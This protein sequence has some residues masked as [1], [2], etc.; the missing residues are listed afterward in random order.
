MVRFR[1]GSPKRSS[2]HCALKP[3]L[4]VVTVDLDGVVEGLEGLEVVG[5]LRV[6]H[7]NQV[8]DLRCLQGPGVSLLPGF[9]NK[10][11]GSSL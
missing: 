8:V 2:G 7:A 9:L 10:K 3:Y 1:V 4:R 6:A 5:D 11:M